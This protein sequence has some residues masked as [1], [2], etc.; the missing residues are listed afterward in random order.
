MT[1]IPKG[2][3][4]PEYYDDPVD[5]LYLSYSEK[6]NPYFKQ[7]GFTPN[8]ITTLSFIF[9]LITVWLYYKQQY[10]L[11]GLSYIV[12]YFFDVMDGNFARTYKMTSQFGSLYDSVSD[13]TVVILL[14]YLF[15]TNKHFGKNGL[16]IKMIMT[17]LLIG[18]LMIFGYHYSCQDKYYEEHRNNSDDKTTTNMPLPKC[19]DHNHMYYTRYFG[20][21]MCATFM[22][23]IIM[24]HVFLCN[25]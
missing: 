10:I 24:S 14:A 2:R 11:A 3:K 1:D 4:L 6:L 12:S 18:L 17:L 7:L 16:Y 21:G 8:G 15:I 23:L 13:V 25:K 19:F 5:L 9:G 22:G 20:T